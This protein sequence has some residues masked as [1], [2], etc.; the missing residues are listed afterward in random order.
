VIALRRQDG[1]SALGSCHAD[2][3]SLTRLIVDLVFGVEAH[4]QGCAVVHP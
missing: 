2:A 1:R 3:K 4:G